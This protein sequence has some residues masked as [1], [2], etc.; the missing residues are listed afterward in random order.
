MKVV[1][2]N[3]IF[4]N[5]ISKK[6]TISEDNDEEE[7]VSCV[8]ELYDHLLENEEAFNFSISIMYLT[9][10]IVNYVA[11]RKYPDDEVLINNVNFLRSFS[12]V[13]ELINIMDEDIFKTLCDD[14]VLFDTSCYYVRKKYIM[15]SMN[16]KNFL[17]KMVPNFI[18]DVIMYSMKYTPSYILNEYYKRYKET[19]DK[20][21]ALEDSICF[22]TEFLIKLEEDDIDNYKEVFYN[23]VRTYYVYNKYLL[24]NKEDLDKYAIDIMSMIESNVKDLMMFS[25]NNGDLLEP[26]VRDYLSYSL[27]PEDKKIEIQNFYKNKDDQTSL[28]RSVINNPNTKIRKKL[29]DDFDVMNSFDEETVDYYANELETLK[30]S[31]VFD[32]IVNVLYIDSM[33]IS[34]YDY[35]AFPT[36]ED[37]RLDFEYLKEFSDIKDF[38]MQLLENDMML[39]DAI[40]KSI[41][42]YNMSMLSKKE[43][44]KNLISVNAYDSYISK[45]YVLDIFEFNRDYDVFD[46]IKLYDEI[47]IDVRDKKIAAAEATACLGADLLDLNILDKKNYDSIIYELSK[48]FY[49]YNKYLFDQNLEFERENEEII[50]LMEK[51]LDDFLNKVKDDYLLR[52][53]IICSFYEYVSC[54]KTKKQDILS[55][56]DELDNAGKVKIFSKKNKNSN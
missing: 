18:N 9:S 17:L 37:V 32:E 42:F 7:Y 55:Y 8:R 19:G 46:A 3:D 39:L 10:Y 33:S 2:Y 4:R 28:N 54:D 30:N 56:F 38:K 48:I 35:L 15:E 41:S 36:D 45:G 44:L 24:S 40:S 43:L 14:T 11:F 25:S 20:N 13:D 51:N 23:M 22:G 12:S 34:Y 52:E 5:F 29:S 27:L 21:V 49:E 50:I 6:L 16:N 31:D 1:N 53:K 47:Y 26:I